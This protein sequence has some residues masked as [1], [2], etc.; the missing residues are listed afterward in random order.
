MDMVADSGR[1]KIQTDGVI[2]A[3]K[4]N[5]LTSDPDHGP[6][7]PEPFDCDITLHEPESTAST[8]ED[9]GAVPTV[10]ETGETE[11]DKF[12]ASGNSEDD[13]DGVQSVN[14]HVDVKISVET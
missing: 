10:A 6:P 8:G 12:D 11:T 13:G 1:D 2:I 3:E 14:D 5:E 9:L 7:D 4:D